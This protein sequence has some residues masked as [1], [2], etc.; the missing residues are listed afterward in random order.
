MS[1]SQSGDPRGKAAA[2]LE[3]FVLRARRVCAHS[4]A[5]DPDALEALTKP[6]W[7]IVVGE[8]T[9]NA[10]VTRH[11]PPEEL[12]ESLAA[13]V[14]PLILQRDP[15][16]YGK[17]LNA[18]GLLLHDNPD[19]ADALAY[20]QWLR[21]QWSAINSDSDEIRA[22]SIQKGRVDGEGPTS[23]I[24]DNTLAFAW[25]YGDVVHADAARRNAASDFDVVDRFEAAVHVVA[26]VAWLAHATLDFVE[27]LRDAGHLE[28]DGWVFEEDVVVGVTEITHGANVLV[29]PVGTPKPESL[30]ED[31]SDQW[32]PLVE[33][34]SEMAPPADGAEA[35]APGRTGASGAAD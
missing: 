17:V 35:D 20:V 15:V 21:G 27:Q 34:R 16:H 22:Y 2:A 14:R 3:A 26:R 30:H 25:F 11:L 4:L 5:S 32:K 13:R 7:N 23:D 29:A 12:V 33:M 10:T 8:R 9:G 6:K 19:A 31:F 18:L 28:T 1:T 24:S